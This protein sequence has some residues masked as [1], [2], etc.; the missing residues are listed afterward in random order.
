MALDPLTAPPADSAAT[1]A[2]GG[3]ALRHAVAAE[4]TKLTS[5][6]S[7]V[8]TWL[9]MVVL[10]LAGG[11]LGVLGADSG[12]VSELSTGLGGFLVGQLAIVALGVLAIA[13]EYG[14]GML[15][16]T[17]TTV[18]RRARI[19]TAKALVLSGAAL[20][21]GT[22]AVGLNAWLATTLLDGQGRPPTGGEL[23]RTVLGGGLYL[24]LLGLLSLSVG[25]LLKHSAGALG[26]MLGLLLLP[27]IAGVFFI[28]SG[29]GEFLFT[30]SSIS[31]SASLFGRG[32]ADQPWW[33]LLGWMAGAI[34]VLLAGAYAAVLRRDV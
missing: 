16:T 20:G 28:D 1:R 19:L 3:P 32:F 24:A 34:A 31:I 4:W 15:R 9:L 13:P 12:T 7:T 23:V 18:P 25:T 27:T 21:P 17:F 10:I 14:T 26:V 6:R 33:A 30:H 2:T 22:A 29:M 8:W 11:G 5:V